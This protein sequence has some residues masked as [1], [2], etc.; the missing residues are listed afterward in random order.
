MRNVTLTAP[1]FHNGQ[2][3][4]LVVAIRQHLDPY[5]FARAY[6]E[7]G[8]HLMAPT[9]IDAISPILASGS[10]ITEEQVGLLFAFLEALEDRRAGS[11]SR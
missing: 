7:G 5:R 2:A 11:L 9:E 10:L 4:T 3:D 6:A 8:E 1:Y